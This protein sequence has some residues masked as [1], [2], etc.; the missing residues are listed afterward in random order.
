MLLSLEF[1]WKEWTDVWGQ[2][3][4]KWLIFHRSLRSKRSYCS[5][6]L[7]LNCGHRQFTKMYYFPWLK[8]Q[9]FPFTLKW[10][11]GCNLSDFCQTRSM[12][13]AM[14]CIGF[15]SDLYLYLFA[16]THIFWLEQQFSI[17]L[18][19]IQPHSTS[20]PQRHGT[21][22]KASAAFC[23]CQNHTALYL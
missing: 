13:A 2:R 17:S 9:T 20:W 11:Y 10:K 6:K 12:S 21:T 3:L 16:R 1:Y 18:A 7:E 22:R 19:S 8:W 23:I 4:M 15:A 14:H 5:W